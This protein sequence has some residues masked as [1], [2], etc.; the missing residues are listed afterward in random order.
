MFIFFLVV[1]AHMDCLELNTEVVDF[2][3]LLDKVTELD[4]LIQTFSIVAPNVNTQS[5]EEWTLKD[6]F[7]K[8]LKLEISLINGPEKEYA[9]ELLSEIIK[10]KSFVLRRS[11]LFKGKTKVSD[12]LANRKWSKFKSIRRI[13]RFDLTTFSI[14]QISNAF[15]QVPNLECLDFK[16]R[17]RIKIFKFLSFAKLAQIPQNE[18]VVLDNKKYIFK[19]V[20]CIQEVFQAHLCTMQIIK[21][22]SDLFQV[23]KKFWSTNLIPKLHGYPDFVL[24]T[25]KQ[26]VETN[27]FYLDLFLNSVKKT[28][29]HDTFEKLQSKLC[30]KAFKWNVNY[31]DY[32]N[33]FFKHGIL[34]YNHKK[35]LPK[36]AI[37][38]YLKLMKLD[39]KIQFI[40]IN[41]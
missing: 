40:L 1:F 6:W 21:E 33:F 38:K 41:L 11:S 15:Q 24:E 35:Y 18:I 10:T 8:D 2:L 29:G 31:F 3:M 7:L 30:E 5:L 26:R 14:K 22:L 34:H 19:N 17:E 23:K 13:V 12:L 20:E 9:M 36:E 27:L 4:Y 25:I 32:G 39:S 16:S 37:K 28:T